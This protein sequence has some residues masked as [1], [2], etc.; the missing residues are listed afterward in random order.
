SLTISFPG[1]ADDVR[2]YE[3]RVRPRDPDRPGFVGTVFL[4]RATAAI[5]RMSFTFTPASY[6]DPYLDYIRISLDNSLWMGR[7]WLPYRQEAELRRELPALDFL[8]GSVIRGRF[9]I[10]GYDF[11]R[12]LPD[13]L[14]A[15][16][17]VSAV[18]EPLRRA[19]PFEDSLYSDLEEQGLETPPSLTEVREQARDMVQDRY[20][21]GLRRLRLHLPS[22]S[23]AYRYDRAEGSFAGLGTTFRPGADLLLQAHAGYAFGREKPAAS[24]RLTGVESAG[25]GAWGEVWWNRLEDVGPVPAASGVVNTLAALTAGE[26]WTDPFFTGGLAAGFRSEGEIPWL[27][28]ARPSVALRWARHRSGRDVV[29]G[30]DDDF[31]PVRPAREGDRVTVEPG[32][33]W[34]QGATPEDGAGAELGA[35][36]PLGGLSELSGHRALLTVAWARE[37]GWRDLELSARLDA[38]GVWGDDAP[39]QLLFLLGGR[40]TVLGHAFRGYVGDRFW[41]IRGGLERSLVEPWLSLRA[42]ASA[43][44]SHLASGEL[45]EGWA[46]LEPDG[47]PL[48]GVGAG[49][50]LLWDVLRVDVGR[51]LDGGEWEAAFSVTHRLRRWL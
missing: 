44:Q 8:A 42:F 51:G 20:L 16:G 10:R 43:G 33:T 49:L 47:G 30:V 40:E 26:D 18:P 15:G 5:V 37:G 12:D 3:L 34:G 9:E 29:S 35:S 31:R 38:G 14:F 39:P 17:R 11:N 46:D 41:L 25:T 4:D 48:V 7:Y 32:L 45:P 24:L 1:G 19:Y 13:G 2:V 36:L 27:A 28:G 50:G 6:V 23:S 21:S 22:A